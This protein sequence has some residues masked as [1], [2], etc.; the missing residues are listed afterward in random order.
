MK[1]YSDL[2]PA[3]K[4]RR[5][6]NL[7]LAALAHY[8]IDHSEI[9]YHGL[10]TNLLYRVSSAG[11]ERFMLRL[12]YPGW[13]TLED[14]QS[15]AM[16]LEA[17]RRNTSIPA[18]VAIPAACGRWHVANGLARPARKHAPPRRVSLFRH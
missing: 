2:T 1:P 16:W 9:A 6:H 14:L 5:L 11:G 4:L 10:D 8:D 17:I 3:G 7:A 18:P 12:A 13:R 15:E